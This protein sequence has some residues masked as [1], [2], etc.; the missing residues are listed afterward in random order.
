MVRWFKFALFIGR[1]VLLVDNDDAEIGNGRKERG[2]GANDDIDLAS[3]NTL[4]FVVALTNAQL[5][6]NNCHASG[7]TACYTLYR[8]G[9]QSNFRHQHNPSFALRDQCC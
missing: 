3:T 2:A 9:G 4:P 5:A 7:K 6:M 8:L 1:F